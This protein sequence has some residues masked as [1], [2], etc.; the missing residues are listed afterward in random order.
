[1]NTIFSSPRILFVQVSEE[2]IPDYLVMVNDVENV[3]R[4]LAISG[5]PFTK[6]KEVSWVNCKLSDGSP[7]FSLLEK[8]TG[9]FIGNIE[10]MSIQDGKGELGIAITAAMQDK[11][12]GTEAIR[13]LLCY[14]ARRYGLKKVVLRARPWNPRALRVYEKCG[15]TE[16]G[17]N[18]DHVYMQIDLPKKEK[19]TQ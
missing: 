4:F 5:T 15:F 13:A 16:Y 1:M 12:F 10:F 14:G 6:E 9:R 17:R 8:E 3:Q 11:G 19:D 2:L 7:V 18:E